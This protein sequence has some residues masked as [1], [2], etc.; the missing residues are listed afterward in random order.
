VPDPGR[1]VA[2]VAGS[3]REGGIFIIG[4]P[5][6]W[7]LKGLVTKFTPFRFH[8]FVARRFL[9]YPEAGTPGTA[10]YR[11]Y[12]RLQL[13]PRRLERIAAGAGLSLIYA[14]HYAGHTED[15]LPKPA[16]MVWK[17]LAR[18]LRVL[19]GGRYDPLLSELIVV[20]RR[21][22]EVATRS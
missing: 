3:L 7:S 9:G 16:R 8:V 19:T 4:V 13:S 11:T 20:F 17:A 6:L 15:K 5:Y 2:N 10:P 14:D 1:A 22:A 12:L 18:G 21:D